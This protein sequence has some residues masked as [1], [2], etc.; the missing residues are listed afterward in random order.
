MAKMMGPKMNAEEMKTIS[1]RVLVGGICFLSGCGG[2]ARRSTYTPIYAVLV[3]LTSGGEEVV[4]QE[5]RYFHQATGFLLNKTGLVVTSYHA[6]A[7][8]PSIRVFLPSKESM[9]D[10]EVQLKD[11]DNDI[12]ILALKDFSH[13]EVFSGDIPYA[14]RSSSTV[15]LGEDVF[16]LGFPLGK[17]LGKSVKFSSG[18]VSSLSGL[19]DNPSLFQVS[20]PIQPG[21]SGGPLFDRNGNLVGI[22][23]AS[24]EA[25]YFYENVDVIPRDANFAVKSDC[26]QNLVSTLPESKEIFDREAALE[27]KPTQE[28]VS[29]LVPYVVTVYVK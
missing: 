2:S 5:R 11:I 26:L 19:L 18:T 10:A 24:P 12:A 28:Q 13:E 16:T 14:V 8:Y 23:L 9:F 17:V 25:K 4:L 7:S 6:L 1:R 15:R 22:A 29:A 27:G 20:N 3:G 21:S